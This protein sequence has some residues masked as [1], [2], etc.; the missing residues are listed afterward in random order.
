MQFYYLI[1]SYAVLDYT[2]GFQLRYLPCTF[3]LL[4]YVVKSSVLSGWQLSGSVVLLLGCR[5]CVN[6]L[7]CGLLPLSFQSWRSGVF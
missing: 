1:S 3:L 7:S 4:H 6:I 5:L 2:F